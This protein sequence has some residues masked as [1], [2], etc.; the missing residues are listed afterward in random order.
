M[1]QIKLFV[2]I[3]SNVES[4]EDRINQWLK[5]SGAKVVNVF[6]NIAPQTVTKDQSG[7][8]LGERRFSSSDMFVAIVYETA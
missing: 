8:S 5:E 7:T 2:D 4:L 3:E 6:G 1:H